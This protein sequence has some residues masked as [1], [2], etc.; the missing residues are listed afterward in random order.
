[1]SVATQLPQRTRSNSS[2]TSS[3]TRRTRDEVSLAEEWEFVRNYLALETLRLGSRLRVDAAIEEDGLEC[4]VPAFCLQPLVENAIRHA[5]APR[6]GGGTIWIKAALGNGKLRLEVQDD[7]PGTV[8]DAGR[9]NER[10]GLRLVRQRLEA[11]YGERAQFEVA[12]SPGAGFRVLLTIPVARRT[13]V[14]APADA[15][16]ADR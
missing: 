5:V 1:M 14:V 3:A 11:L 16:S 2:P 15:T 12:T 6:A 7:G 4:V 9:T 10:L 13:P 8:P